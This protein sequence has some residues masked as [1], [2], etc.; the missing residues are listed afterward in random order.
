[1]NVDSI[2]KAGSIKRL[3]Y[4]SSFAAVGHPC[5]EGHQYTEDSWADMEQERRPERAAW[6]MDV[7]AKNREVAYA[8]SDDH[9]HHIVV[10]AVDHVRS[11]G[12][13]HGPHLHDA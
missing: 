2:K 4:T 6:N 7:V 5:D 8:I 11:E 10:D 12:S 1:M 3:V 13:H 9:I